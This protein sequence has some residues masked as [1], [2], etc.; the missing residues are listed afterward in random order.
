MIRRR[1]RRV[2]WCVSALLALCSMIA[3]AAHAEDPF[4]VTYQV[5]R[6]GGDQTQ[7]VG[8]VFN[9]GRQEVLDVSVTAEALD[10][11]GKVV[12]RGIAYVSPRIPGQSSASFVAKIPT[13]PGA[14]KFRASVTSFRLGF[15]TQAP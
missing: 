2:P 15:G 6:S 8:T 14:A 5:E 13:V 12:A 11:K 7:I 1:P 4:R 3:V 9:E 10:G